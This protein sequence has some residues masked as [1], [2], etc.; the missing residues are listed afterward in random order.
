MTVQL[1]KFATALANKAS[2]ADKVSADQL[3]KLAIEE[4][5]SF[6]K[7]AGISKTSRGSKVVELDE[8]TSKRVFKSGLSAQELVVMG[9]LLFLELEHD[10]ESEE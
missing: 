3:V 10:H 5:L 4:G 2:S 8:Y 6:Q 1:G 9:L 7:L